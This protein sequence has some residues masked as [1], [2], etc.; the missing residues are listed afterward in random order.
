ML[1]MFKLDGKV[2]I[3]TGASRGLGQGIIVGL[4]KA[5]ADIVGV[6][7]SDMSETRKLVESTGKKFVE[8]K[9]DLTK[10][11]KLDDIIQVC[12]KEFGRVDILVNNA[13][14]I[15]R[16]DAIN[17]TEKDWDDILN[18]NLKTVFFLSQKVAKEFMKK[19]NR[20]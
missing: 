19:K 5:G 3:V 9:A 20:W 18:L 17:Y 11:D 7:Q 6:G 14:T 8:V 2:A 12:K 13:G 1:D 10:Q 16:E 4:A 15:R